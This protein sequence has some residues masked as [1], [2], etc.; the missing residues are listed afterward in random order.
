MRTHYHV[1]ENTPGYL[2]EGMPSTHFAK[3]D[4]SDAAQELANHYRQSWG[5]GVGFHVTGNKH[6][7]YTIEDRDKMYDL[8]RVIWIQPCND[9]ECLEHL[10]EEW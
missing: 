7:G 9:A 1:G 3:A 4:A 10:D 2:P 5:P 8:V 6:D